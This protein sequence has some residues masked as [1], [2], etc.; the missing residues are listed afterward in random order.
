MNLDLRVF[1]GGCV[2]CCVCFFGGLFFLGMWGGFGGGGRVTVTFVI[3]SIGFVTFVLV[4]V[5]RFGVCC[6]FC[7]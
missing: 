5:V 1:L 3:F 7:R 4:L 2:F 6:I